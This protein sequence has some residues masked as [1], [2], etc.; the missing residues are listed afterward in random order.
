MDRK[1]CSLSSQE[2]VQMAWAPGT[3]SFAPMD[4]ND[5][6]DAIVI[7][8]P[9]HGVNTT[10]WFSLS[11]RRCPCADGSMGEAYY[12]LSNFSHCSMPVNYSLANSY[13]YNYSHS[14]SHMIQ[15]PKMP[16]CVIITPTQTFA[17]ATFPVI[18]V[19]YGVMLSWLVGMK[20]GRQVLH[21]ILARGYPNWTDHVARRMLSE[22]PSR[23][24]RL[25]RR[26]WRQRRES[27]QLD[28]EQARE[29]GVGTSASCDRT[30]IG[31]HTTLY[32][33]EQGDV[34]KR[35]GD[36]EDAGD[37]HRACTICFGP[38]ENGDRV[39]A[40]PCNHV[41]HAD[42]LK[43]WLA[44]RQVCPLCLRDD[45]VEQIPSCTNHTSQNFCC[46]DE[47]QPD[48]SSTSTTA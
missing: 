25:I 4:Q 34:A 6:S 29:D 38:I 27:L 26:N 22:E 8:D 28:A 10:D 23:A 39:G 9:T 16:Q 13:D 18:M 11:V 32:S 2:V 37:D 3:G 30:S 40:I 21:Y 48:T 12:C 47:E 5:N 46:N 42:C 33:S 19:W 1:L 43:T 20:S 44:R 45:I 7:S 41:F 15:E 36:D 31:L 14:N 24:R 17:R 35:H